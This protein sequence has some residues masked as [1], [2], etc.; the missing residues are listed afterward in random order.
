MHAAL[1]LLSS[2]QVMQKKYTRFKVH[3]KDERKICIHSTFQKQ[4]GSRQQMLIIVC[5]ILSRDR[6][7][8]IYNNSL[9]FQ[10]RTF[11]KMTGVVLSFRHPMFKHLRAFLMSMCVLCMCVG[12]GHDAL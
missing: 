4:N 2:M 5:S 9:H 6:I 8:H 7:E 12:N 11:V 10:G 3:P 1:H